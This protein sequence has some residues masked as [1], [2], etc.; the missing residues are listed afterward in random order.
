MCGIWFYIYQKGKSTLSYAEI[1]E[2]FM[3]IQHRGP[4]NST[5]L[6]LEQ[7]GLYIGFH[8]LSINGLSSKGNQPFIHE[9][10]TTVTYCISNAEIYNYKD[11]AQQYNI[12]LTTGSDCEILIPLYQKLGDEF[13]KF[14]NAEFSI[15][16]CSINKITGDIKTYITRDTTGKRGLYYSGYKDIEYVFSSELK[17]IPFLED[18]YNLYTMSQ[19][20]PRQYMN[21]TNTKIVNTTEYMNFDNIP[22]TIK[23]LEIAKKLIYTIFIK[24]VER[25]LMTDRPIIALLSGGLDSSLCVAVLSKLLR[26]K[27]QKLRT[28]CIG[29]PESTDAKYAQMVADYCNTD[30]TFLKLTEQD[31]IDAIPHVVKTIES[32][33]ITTVRA[34]IGQWLVSKWILQNTNAKVVYTGDG[35]DELISGYMYC[36]KCPNTIEL[37]KD[38]KRLMNEIHLYDVLRGDRCISAHGQE[39]RLSYLDDEF[40]HT[41]YSIDPELRKPTNG[42]EKWL[43]REA[44]K[45]SGLLPEKV[46]YRQKEAF[47]DGVSGKAKSLFEILQDD[48]DKKVSLEDMT[49]SEF[50]A[51]TK[52]SWYYKYLFQQYY[53]NNVWKI[54]P[55]YWMPKWCENATDPS[56]R[57]LQVY[58]KTDE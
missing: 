16:I 3:K 47:S 42:K 28:I 40:I 4:D 13:V 52:E 44:F 35:S 15:I 9:T 7:Y 25:R 48:I 43:L 23:S 41:V 55:F 51:N 32:Y 21:L 39:N 5:L 31:F 6:H 17:G 45:E 12:P 20:P 27:G 10:D 1:Y 50:K 36:H 49:T 29:L 19:F 14:I 34:S 30:H 54:I 2:S 57:T 56:A 46:L 37:D 33:D 8:R 24:S 11:L 22:V 26:E 58:D 38:S 53:G 18:K